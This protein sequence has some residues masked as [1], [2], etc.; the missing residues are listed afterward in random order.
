MRLAIVGLLLCSLSS[1]DSSLELNLSEVDEIIYSFDDAS[2][3]PEYHRSY[4][5]TIKENSGTIVVDSYGDILAEDEFKLMDG[6]FAKL[7]ESINSANLKECDA[8]NAPKCTG[9]TGELISIK[10]G[11][12]EVYHQYIDHCD[13]NSNI[14]KCGDFPTVIADIK[15]FVPDLEGM[16]R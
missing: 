12:K 15:N 7:I 3:P 4:T 2:V 9:S 10:E 1:C 8:N 11:G 16:L 13:K 5:I 14:A 6:E